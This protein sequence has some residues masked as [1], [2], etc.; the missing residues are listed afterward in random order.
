VACISLVLGFQ[1]SSA[2][3]SAY[4][5]AVTLTMLTTTGLFYFATRR[6]WHWKKPLAFGLC[7]VFAT[8]EIAFFASN[9]LKVL[10]GGWLPLM[11]GAV[12]FY[13]MTT[14]KKGRECIREQFKH[15]MPLTEF[16]ASINL[17]GILSPNLSPH[18]VK[19]T[20]IF[21]SS[22]PT[23]TPN[24]LLQNLKHNHVLHERNIVLTIATD[25]VPYRETED[26][27]EIIPLECSFYRIIAHF[28]FMEFSTI[29]EVVA[30]AALQNFEIDLEK[31]TFFLGRESL[32]HVEGKGLSRMSKSVFSVM[33]RNA[34]D[35]AK[36]F[37]M[38]SSRTIEIG[39]PVEI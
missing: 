29:T 25:R 6:V 26:R 38:P 12:L 28:G 33:S 11:I 19:G 32:N 24:A 30:A 5:I 1:S 22:S 37:R 20:A 21:L 39:L 9:A 27:L 23:A 34:E 36:F 35:A 3:A 4:G 31:T 7:A 13:A 18:H 15:A 14:W 8:V 16:L 10:H 17:S 2:L